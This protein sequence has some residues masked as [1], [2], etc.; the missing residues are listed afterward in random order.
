MSVN[1]Y[2]VDTLCKLLDLT[3]RR[4]QQ[5]TGEGVLIKVE[6]GRYDLVK[7]VRGYV[8]YLRDRALKTDAA[9]TE[10]G[11]RRR[12]LDAEAEIFEINRDTL[13]HDRIR[14]GEVSEAWRRIGSEVRA[15]ALALP[16]RATPLLHRYMKD[17]VKPAEVEAVLRRLIEE[18]LSVLSTIQ[19]NIDPDPKPPE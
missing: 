6:R 7:S 14:R 1:T 11:S 12:R 13:R 15:N 8:I 18:L 3:P 9:G 5:L 19:I 17:K 16:A 2:P 10:D 4:V